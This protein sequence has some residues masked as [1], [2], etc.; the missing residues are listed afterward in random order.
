MN[1]KH[2]TLQH[3]ADN[4]PQTSESRIA[5]SMYSCRMRIL[6]FCH[7]NEIF[8]QNKVILFHDFDCCIHNHLTLQDL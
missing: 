2:Y 8:T 4:I 1:M 6:S 3:A 5:Q 7:E